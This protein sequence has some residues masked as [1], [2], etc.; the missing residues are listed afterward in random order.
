MDSSADR[1]SLLA[2]VEEAG[3]NGAPLV[4]LD[5]AIMRKAGWDKFCDK[6]VMIDAP[7]EVRLARARSR[8]WSEAEFEVRETAQETLAEKREMADLVI[9]NSGPPEATRAAVENLWPILIG[10]KSA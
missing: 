2:Q 10:H 3:R 9:D 1:G 7:R 5:A 6:I 8:G 4:V